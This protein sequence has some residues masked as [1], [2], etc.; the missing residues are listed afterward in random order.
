[1]QMVSGLS[2]LE[3]H[4]RRGGYGSH[5]ALEAFEIQLN[6]MRLSRANQKNVNKLPL[7][8]K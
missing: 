7:E 5:A 8:A 2:V 6:V 3:S 1:M 4:V